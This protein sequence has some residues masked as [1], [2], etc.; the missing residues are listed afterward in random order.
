[1]YRQVLLDKENTRVSWGT[2]D[3][4]DC[5][6]TYYAYLNWDFDLELFEDNSYIFVVLDEKEEY[7]LE[8]RKYENKLKT[9]FRNYFLENI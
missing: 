5:Y 6:V 8:V 4:N 7:V 1:M 9:Q 3:D 2:R